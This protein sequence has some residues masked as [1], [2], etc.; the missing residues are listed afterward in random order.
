MIPQDAFDPV[1]HLRERRPETEAG[2]SARL[3]EERI[4]WEL[5]RNAI[6]LGA[7]IHQERRR[8]HLSLRCVAS[9]AGVA[10]GTAQAAEAGVVCSLETYVRLADAL[11]LKA[12]FRIED[13]RR[14]EP[15]AKRA[16]DP[17]HA[18][19]GEAE[20]A[21]LKS[22][23]FA[24]GIDEPFQHFQFSGRADVVAWSIERRL[25]LHIE[26][27]TQIPDVQACFGSFNAKRAY[28]GSELATRLGVSRWHSETHVIAAIWSA[29]TLH[30]IRMH[31]ASFASVCPDPTSAFDG[32]WREVP[33]ETGRHS[34]L[35][36]FDPAEGRRSDRRRRLGLCELE[37]LRARSRPVGPRAQLTLLES[38]ALLPATRSGACVPRL[39]R[40]RVLTTR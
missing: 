13:P 9:D 17:V 16:I 23:G 6:T 19:M 1:E 31:Q 10:L 32:W 40:R 27:K 5:A 26:N 38:A 2:R 30:T 25:L 29:E 33:P 3:Q 35:V 15:A 20:A 7:A 12:E 8:R 11:R 14:R 36:V 21:H 24:L 18:A 39:L 22:R 28:L 34:I 37:R 4:G